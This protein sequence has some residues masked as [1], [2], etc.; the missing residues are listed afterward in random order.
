MTSKGDSIVLAHTHTH[1]RA[2]TGV[3]HVLCELT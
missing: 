1:T 3:Q 2:H